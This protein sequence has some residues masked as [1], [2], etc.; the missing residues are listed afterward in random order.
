MFLLHPSQAV[1][2]SWVSGENLLTFCQQL[3]LF[4][5]LTM[6][7]FERLQYL[8]IE[9]TQLENDCDVVS[10]TVLGLTVFRFLV[11]TAPHQQ[12]L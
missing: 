3:G 5:C 7:C 8:T 11:A 2:S 1:V 9:R 6:A 10:G 12:I 4:V